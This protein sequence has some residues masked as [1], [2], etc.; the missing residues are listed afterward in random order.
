MEKIVLASFEF[1]TE[2]ISKAK[3]ENA[4]LKAEIIALRREQSETNKVI[5][6][7]GQV[8]EQ[9]AA[10]LAKNDAKLKDLN[11]SYQS[12]IK[13]INAN[14]A[15]TSSLNKALNEEIK[16]EQ[17][18]LNNIQKLTQARKGLDATTAD[19][20]KQIE[21]INA[22]IDENNKFVTENS[23]AYTKQKRNVGNY[24]ESIK[25]ALN[26]Q[27]LF[28]GSLNG[29]S[30]VTSALQPIL[31]AIQ[32]EVA[33][34]SSSFKAAA[35]STEGMT[36][37]QRASAVATAA[38]SNALKILRVALISTGVGAL[39]VALGSLVTFLSSTQRGID[40]VT[41]V[42]RPLQA[43]FS[44]L[45]GVVQGLGGSLF[46]AFSNPQQALKDLADFV[47]QNLINRFTAFGKILEGI[48]TLD[49]D[50]L[51]DGVLQAAT[52]VE[53]VVGKVT[54]ASE[55]TGKFL[56]EAIDKGKQLDA[57][58]KDI[59]Q[60]E[61][62]ILL[63]R[64]EANKQIKEQEV[65]AKNTSLSASERNKAAQEALRISEDAISK[66]KEI[67][68]L[69]IQQE[70]IQQS[71]NDSGR[72]DL[73]ELN[74]IKAE[75]IAL[76]EKAAA[77]QL[78]FVGVNKA[79]QRERIAAAKE[80]QDAIKARKDTAIKAAK[81]ELDFFKFTF[82]KKNAT[83][84]ESLDF[85]QNVSD[86][87]LAILDKEFEAGKLSKTAYELEKAKIAQDQLTATSQIVLDQ[88][89]RE[90][91]IYDQTNKSRIDSNKLL[92]DEILKAEDE[93]INSLLEKQK[94]FARLKLEQGVIS[95]QAYADEVAKIDADAQ[96]KK[97]EVEAL[98]LEQEEEARAINLENL[99][100]Y[101]QTVGE[102]EFVLK[103]EQLERERIAEIEA[104]EK[105]GA[106]VA[107]INKRYEALQTQLNRKE[108]QG[109]LENT[110]DTLEGANQALQSI[111]LQ[112]KEL[113]SSLALANTYL[114][115]NKV[116]ADPKLSFPAN[117][118]QAAVIGAQGFANVAR[119]NSIKFAQGGEVDGM[120]RG[121]SHSDGGMLFTVRNRKNYVGEFE[122]NEF[123]VNKKAAQR[124][125]TLL[126]R[127]NSDRFADGGIVP[128]NIGQSVSSAVSSST[129]TPEQVLTAIE[130][131]VA[132][133]E[134]V[135]LA[136]ETY[137]VATSEIR[138]KNEAVR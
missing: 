95:E 88:A 72:K 11:K 84:S 43:V 113:S 24:T 53:D 86:Q 59:E 116:L 123:I 16:T 6:E 26:G 8:T 122:G 57:I 42:T 31:T 137:K 110:I 56:Q 66:E 69:K 127:I 107:L 65:I 41:S 112:S 58:Q 124:H 70:T 12:N 67:L 131:R 5:K 73:T 23:D 87:R 25:E 68:D 133:L 28:N 34:I 61:A 29:F 9:Q 77:E 30:S 54:A 64:A 83:V 33:G 130:S 17:Q 14:A 118:I 46:D 15:S 74:K 13:V 105:V 20:R 80:Q 99:I 106:D 136:S 38:S 100:A 115:I 45:L 108:T 109:R 2:Q 50:K 55:A 119:I 4:K 98:R 126:E 134:V 32:V 81:E 48:V 90:L 117:F 125:R 91:A 129:M 120:Q 76:D 101:R 36:V 35:V 135:N 71:L 44:S 96:E 89:S 78:K 128:G 62:D 103:Q 19:G 97:N 39:V 37:A 21:L 111:G 40:A 138:V 92:T 75:Q 104:A 3:D 79:L 85:E 93:R 10:S 27:N 102:S 63:T 60:R 47:Q 94:E 121:P 52:G 7:S 49:F 51:T 114:A 132:R 18:A 1:D 22:K 82:D